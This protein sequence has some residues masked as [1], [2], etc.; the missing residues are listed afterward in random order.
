MR[1]ALLAVVLLG[2]CASDDVLAEA[3]LTDEDEQP[4][5]GANVVDAIETVDARRAELMDLGECDKA[6]TRKLTISTAPDP[7]EYY[8]T[9]IYYRHVR[10]PLPSTG[11]AVTIWLCGVE[12]L[13]PSGCPATTPPEPFGCTPGPNCVDSGDPRPI[14]EGGSNWC[15]SFTPKIRETDGLVQI[16][17]G[18]KVII[19]NGGSGAPA[20]T[21]S[22]ATKVYLK[23]E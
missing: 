19:E 10:V 14:D 22:V 20:T 21:G 7:D 5:S 1:T 13:N 8:E 9:T 2:A 16:I 4:D 17:C 3:D 23:V 6:A 11:A 18:K 12:C 15:T